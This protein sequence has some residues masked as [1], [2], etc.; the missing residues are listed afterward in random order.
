MVTKQREPATTIA[1]WKRQKIFEGRSWLTR[2]LLET[3]DGHGANKNSAGLSA[4]PPA[5]P[6]HAKFRSLISLPLPQTLTT[7]HR[8]SRQL[9]RSRFG[10]A[11]PL[12]RQ[13]GSRHS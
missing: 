1:S 2:L 6:D 8:L 13:R 11:P 4:D 10:L 3:T 5:G 7:V 9:T 12:F